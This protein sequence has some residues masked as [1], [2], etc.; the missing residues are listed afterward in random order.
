[1]RVGRCGIDMVIRKGEEVLRDVEIRFVGVFFLFL[2]EMDVYLCDE[3]IFLICVSVG[4][5]FFYFWL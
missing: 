3:E 5:M 2:N 1:M 4:D